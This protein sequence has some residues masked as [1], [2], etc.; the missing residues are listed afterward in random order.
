MSK[1]EIQAEP[2]GDL[3]QALKADGSP[4]AAALRLWNLVSRDACAPK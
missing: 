1:W 2:G 4:A 3:E